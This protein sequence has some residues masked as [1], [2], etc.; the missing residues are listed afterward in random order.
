MYWLIGPSIALCPPPPSVDRQILARVTPIRDFFLDPAN[1]AACRGLLVQR[2]GEL[3]RKIWHPR[4]FKGQA[5]R[6]LIFFQFCLLLA[7]SKPPSLSAYNNLKQMH[8]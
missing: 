2:T 4:N 8:A 1:Y 3:L 7:P 5:S 6:R